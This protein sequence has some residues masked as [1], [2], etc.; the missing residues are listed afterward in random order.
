MISKTTQASSR[1]AQRRR[2]RFRLRRAHESRL[3]RY[4]KTMLS[5]TLILRFIVVL[6]VLWLLFS[7]GIFLAEQR[8][9]APELESFGEALYWG[10]AAFST[11]GI[12]DTPASGLARLI[13]GIWIVTGSVIFF[14]IIIAAITG[15]FMRPLQRPVHRLVETIE[16]NLER[17]QDLSVE[18]LD[19][20]RTTTDTL[21]LHMERLKARKEDAEGKD[22][23]RPSRESSHAD[24]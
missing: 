15:F 22:S 7:A 5:D 20:L 16:Y 3:V 17:L 8:S 23:G 18:E 12:A 6:F 14:G 2:P 19:L 13:G 4:A 9:P 11:A 21:I 24:S 10:V 1:G